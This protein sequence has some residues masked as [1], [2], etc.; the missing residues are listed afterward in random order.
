MTIIT[1]E[2]LQEHFDE[3][4]DRVEEG[5]EFI[6]TIEGVEKAILKPYKED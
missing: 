3:V 5:E 2:E 1:I 6:I 4:F